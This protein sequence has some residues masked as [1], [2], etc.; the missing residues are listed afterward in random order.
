MVQTSR[1]GPFQGTDGA[2]MGL[3]NSQTF[4]NWLSHHCV[5]LFDSYLPEIP[6]DHT[7]AQLRCM[8][9]TQGEVTLRLQAE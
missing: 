1:L 5:S 7:F 3:Q 6:W 4:Y 8:Q 2:Q 9:T